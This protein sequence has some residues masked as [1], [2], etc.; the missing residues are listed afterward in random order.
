MIRD[1]MISLWQKKSKKQKPSH[2][3]MYI[4]ADRTFLLNTKEDKVRNALQ[5]AVTWD[6]N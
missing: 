6:E 3:Y 4:C 2:L 5:Q 1:N